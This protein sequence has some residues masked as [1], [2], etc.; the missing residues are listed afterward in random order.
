MGPE[1]QVA[2]DILERRGM[3]GQAIGRNLTLA[4]RVH[5]MVEILARGI[6]GGAD[7]QFAPALEE[8]LTC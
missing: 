3:G 6:A 7:G 4:D 8:G 2:W 5:D 1:R